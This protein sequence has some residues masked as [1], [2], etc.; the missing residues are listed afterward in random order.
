[1]ARRRIPVG[2]FGEISYTQRGRVWRAITRTRDRDGV[3]RQVTASGPSKESARRTLVA[4]I[5]SRHE[6]GAGVK[7]DGI[8]PDTKISV[9]ADEWIK[10]CE[11]RDLKTRSQRIYRDSVRLHIKPY[12]GEWLVGEA[13]TGA[14]D[15]VLKEHRESGRDTSALRKHLN[16]MF[17]LAVRHDALASNPVTNVAKI[18]RKKPKVRILSDTAQ[19]AEIRGLIEKWETKDRPGPKASRDLRD[20]I[21]LLMST[22]AR[23]GEALALRWQDINLLAERPYLVITGT[24]VQEKGVGTWRQ[25]EGKSL[26]AT[27]PLEIPPSVVTMLLERQMAQGRNPID[28]VFPSRVG[29]WTPYSTMYRRW[30]DATKGTKYDWVTFKT[31]RKQVGTL[32]ARELGAKVAKDQLGHANEVTTETFY[33][34]QSVDAPK[35]SELI[36]SFIRDSAPTG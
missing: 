9:L 34:A 27:R 24:I 12:M 15:R 28:S 23:I 11:M 22:G 16:Q 4:D 13:T 18:K 1:M 32:I 2:G 14:V 19:I 5:E 33:I 3:L 30:N 6:T 7:T 17:A 10:E 36:E 35:V 20:M 21:L 8:A 26:Q 25:D 29:T 31:F